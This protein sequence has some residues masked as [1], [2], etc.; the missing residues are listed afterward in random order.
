MSALSIL[1][2]PFRHFSDVVGLHPRPAHRGPAN[3]CRQVCAG[4]ANQFPPAQRGP[5]PGLG[6]GP[7]IQDP[8]A[9]QVRLHRGWILHDPRRPSRPPLESWPVSVYN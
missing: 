9:L 8:R 5:P 1:I 6:H 7:R 3:F 2:N 4:L